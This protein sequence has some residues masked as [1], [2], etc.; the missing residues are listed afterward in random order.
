[1]LRQ[2]SKTF[3]AFFLVWWGWAN[4]PR[5][6]LHDKASYFANSTQ[7]QLNATSVS[8]STFHVMHQGE[9]PTRTKQG[10]NVFCVLRRPGT[11]FGTCLPE[12][13]QQK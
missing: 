7:N 13:L 8:L 11:S 2:E 5:V 1:M 10:R 12:G 6:I 9:R 4:I 3:S